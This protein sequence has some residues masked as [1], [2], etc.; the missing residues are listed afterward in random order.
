MITPR[1]Q[2]FITEYLKGKYSAAECARRAGYAKKHARSTAYK[3]LQKPKIVKMLGY[4]CDK[5]DFRAIWIIN[6]AMDRVM[7]VM[8]NPK[9]SVREMIHCI[10]FTLMIVERSKDFKNP[11]YTL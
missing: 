11:K 1:Q 10:D 6:R 5:I 2:R 3:I 4:Y 9:T 8:D 7:E